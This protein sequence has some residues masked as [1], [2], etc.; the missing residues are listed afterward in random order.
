[1]LFFAQGADY[2]TRGLPVAD[3][4]SA[5]AVNPAWEA[6]G[7]SPRGSAHLGLPGPQAHPVTPRA[8]KCPDGEMLRLF[9]VVTP[10]WA[11]TCSPG[12]TGMGNMPPLPRAPGSRAR[13]SV[14]VNVTA[15][16]TADKASLENVCPSSQH[17]TCGG[18][19]SFLWWTEGGRVIVSNHESC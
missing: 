12:H 8:L 9:T 17:S 13:L 3:E 18:L 19:S 1:M 7:F 5:Q 11:H 16:P 10:R 6:C 15:Q 2:T 14:G 4:E